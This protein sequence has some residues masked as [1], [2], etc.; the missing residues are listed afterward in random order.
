[1]SLADKVQGMFIPGICQKADDGLSRVLSADRQLVM[2][3]FV[4]LVS[5]KHQKESF[6]QKIRGK[7]FDSSSGKEK[8]LS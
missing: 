6:W 5:G 7:R 3:V 2:G 4:S 8:I 1:M